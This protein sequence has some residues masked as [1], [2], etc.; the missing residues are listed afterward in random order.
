MQRIGRRKE[1]YLGYLSA[2][3][4]LA[5]SEDSTS[6]EDGWGKEAN[7]Y[8]SVGLMKVVGEVAKEW[9]SSWDSERRQLNVFRPLSN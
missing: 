1:V 4:S 2:E 5:C 8:T 9:R 7:F 3:G 6:R